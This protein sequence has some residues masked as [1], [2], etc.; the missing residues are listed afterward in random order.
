[1]GVSTSIPDHFMVSLSGDYGAT[2]HR[3]GRYLTIEDPSDARGVHVM[4]DRSLRD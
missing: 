3:K 4:Q 2:R 1:M